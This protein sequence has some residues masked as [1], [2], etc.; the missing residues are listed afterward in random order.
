M[1]PGRINK[2]IELQREV[3]DPTA[4]GQPDGTWQT[5]A[6][7]WAGFEPGGVSET[8]TG[9]ENQARAVVR[10]VVRRDSGTEGVNAAH[11]VVYDGRV[12][13]ILGVSEIGERND[14]YNIAALERVHERA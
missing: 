11:R 7:R 3:S 9:Q 8:F 14:Q 4:H 2:R 12:F 1:R 5:Y 6:R 13:D 10:F